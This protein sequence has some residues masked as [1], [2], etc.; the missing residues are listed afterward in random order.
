MQRCK[1]SASDLLELQEAPL[2]EPVSACYIHFAPSEHKWRISDQIIAADLI[3]QSCART[4]RPILAGFI[5]AYIYS[6]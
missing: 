2:A 4:F 1:S 5:G 3:R 6:N